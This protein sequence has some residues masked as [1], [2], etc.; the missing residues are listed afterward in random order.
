MK[1]AQMT[2]EEALKRLR[3]WR[4]PLPKV[5]EWQKRGLA[6]YWYYC[7]NFGS[8]KNALLLVEKDSTALAK[9]GVKVISDEELAEGL[10]IA[11][12]HLGHAPETWTQ[13]RSIAGVPHPK[14]YARH[15]SSISL[16]LALLG[17]KSV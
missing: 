3:K 13:I 8:M 10:R 5:S 1:P 11:W 14:T 6:S 2:K 15:F 7:Y 16:A 12:K 4:G 17:V 9:P